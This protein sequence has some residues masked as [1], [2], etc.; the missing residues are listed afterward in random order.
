MFKFSK[1]SELKI[2]EVHPLLQ[3][4]AHLTIQKTTQDFGI[5]STGGKRTAEEQKVLFDNGFSKCDG[6]I[7]KSYHQSGMAIDFVPYVNG[8]F[9]Y[10]DKSAFLAVAKAAFESWETIV[11]KQG[12]FLHW[13]GFWGAID[14]NGNGIL[15][16]NDELGWD[17]AHFELRT[18]PQ[19]NTFDF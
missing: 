10:E 5:L 14:K 9:T 4:L 13:G 1:Q 16:T 18:Y 7:K 11:N 8:G 19:K 17:S 15:E 12:L 3:E 6:T 2:S